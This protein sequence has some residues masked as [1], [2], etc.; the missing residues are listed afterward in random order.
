MR[1]IAANKIMVI[2]RMLII[3]EFYLYYKVSDGSVFS[4]LHYNALL[5]MT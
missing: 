5:S 2:T 1:L 4:E 3:T